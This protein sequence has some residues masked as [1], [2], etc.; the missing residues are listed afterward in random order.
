MTRLT[1]NQPRLY[2]TGLDRGVFYPRV[3]PGET[4]DGLVSIQDD[5]SGA[6]LSFRYIDGAKTYSRRHPEEFAGTI[7]AYTYPDSLYEPLSDDWRKD[8]FGLSYRTMKGESSTL[9]LVY[10]VIISPAG[11]SHQQSETDLFVWNFSTTTDTI[12]GARPS[13][14]LVIETA[15]AYSWTIEALE[16]LLYGSDVNTPQLPN[17]DQVLELFDE[18]SILKVTDNGD[19]S[20]TIEGPDEAVQDLGSGTYRISWP[21]VVFVSGY[22]YRISS[23]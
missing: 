14:H 12:P 18:N 17:P 5:T 4:W 23:L 13:A 21:S 15:D 19:G 11:I 10:N 7:Q 8:P 9:H 22:T 20:Y 16:D 2:E 1:W 6:E 3:G